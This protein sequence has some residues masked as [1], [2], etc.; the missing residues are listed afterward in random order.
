MYCKQTSHVCAQSRSRT[1]DCYIAFMT[2]PL[3]VTQAENSAKF[4]ISIQSVGTFLCANIGT[5]LNILVVTSIHIPTD[6]LLF[7]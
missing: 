2:P 5:F 1:I 7:R 6:V 4:K 3:G